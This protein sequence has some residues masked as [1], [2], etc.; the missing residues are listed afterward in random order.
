VPAAKENIVTDGDYTSKRGT[1]TLRSYQTTGIETADRRLLAPGPS[2]RGYVELPTGSGKTPIAGTLATRSH[3]RHPLSPILFL[4]HRRELVQQQAAEL[5]RWSGLRVSIL[6]AGVDDYDPTAPLIVASIATL[7]A[8]PRALRIKPSLILHDECHHSFVGSEVDRF[9]QTQGDVPVVGFSATP[10]RSWERPKPLL[11]ECLFARGL[12]ELISEGWLAPLK[13]ERIVAPM[14]LTTIASHAGD[15]V[16]TTLAFEALRDD[17]I[18]AIVDAAVPRLRERPGPALCFGVTVEHARRL[19]AT[20]AAAGI[21]TA[22]VWGEQPAGERQAAFEAWRSG[23]VQL[24]VNCAILN[25]GID[26]PALSTIVIAR[27]TRSRR[28]YQQIVG[29]GTRLAPGKRECLVLEACA[30]RRDPEQV[31]LAAVIPEV[32]PETHTQGPPR[33]YLLDPEAAD[34]WT[35]QYHR[36]VGAYSVSANEGVTVYLISEPNS[37]LYRAVVYRKDEPIESLTGTLAR[38]EAMHRA[39]A[40][41]A[42]NASPRLATSTTWHGDSPTEK[43]IAFL[44]RAGIDATKLTKGDA[45]RLIG[46]TFAGWRVPQIVRELRSKQSN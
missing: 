42:Q 27:P 1:P 37:G 11:T 25:E 24:L 20:F 28:L 34:R 33:L 14:N 21:A 36:A 13:S 38:D 35:W 4:A 46:D 40:W 9:L 2:V 5:A 16:E 17:V 30:A 6:M 32:D 45:T 29:R 43:Q 8:R 31:T 18:D 23:N 22:I 10:R 39:G 3:A 26:L 7:N 44:T 12:P 15:Y 19:A 41:L